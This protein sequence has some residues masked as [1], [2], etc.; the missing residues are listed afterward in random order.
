MISAIDL[1]CHSTAS[2]GSLSPSELVGKAA[3]V[4]IKHLALTDHDTTAGVPEATRAAQQHGIQLIPG[5]EIS[6]HWQKRTLHI[7]GLNI[8]PS[9]NAL[10]TGLANAAKQRDQ[11]AEKMAA[12]LEKCGV[13]K[14]LDN[15]RKLANGGQLTRTHF[16]RVLVDGGYCKDMQQAFKKYLGAGKPAFVKAEWAALDEVISWIHAAGGKAVLAHPHKYGMT[17]NWR[18]LTLTAF[19]EAGGDAM[20][21]CCG[22]STANDIATASKAAMQ[23][24]LAGSIGSDFHG[25]GQ[26]WLQLGRVQPL[27]KNIP[28]VWQ[29]FLSTE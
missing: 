1:H 6:A 24:G 23:H 17:A 14:A 19:R 9:A 21:V 13:D 12:K 2:D 28:P 15:A 3:A 22:N 7:V 11:R 25:H 5:V 29:T 4:G 26:P 8:D 20:E 27:P 18:R 16:A 10:H